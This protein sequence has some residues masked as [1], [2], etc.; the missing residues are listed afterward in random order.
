MAARGLLLC[1]IL[2]ISL[3]GNAAESEQHQFKRAI[4]LFTKAE[5]PAS[6]VILAKLVRQHPRKALYWFN[7]GNACFMLEKYHCAEVTFS[8]VEELKSPLAPAAQLY[9]A[10]ALRAGG[11]SPDARSLLQ[12]LLQNRRLPSG[13]HDMATDELL[14]IDNTNADPAAVEALDLYRARKYNQALKAIDRRQG[15]PDDVLMLKAL[16]LIKLDR[17]DEANK[18]LQKVD[19]ANGDVQLKDLA[20]SLVERMRDKYIRPA[21]VFAEVAGG[22]DSNIRKDAAAESGAALFANIGAGKR[23]ASDNLWQ[24]NAAYIG[25]L[26]EAPGHPDL[27]VY[28]HE[29]QTSYGRAVG[30]DL[31]MLTAFL[32]HESWD[33]KPVQLSEGARLR[34]RTGNPHYEFGGDLELS[35]QSSLNGDHPYV[36]GT[37]ASAHLYAGNISVPFYSQVFLDI[38][39]QAIGDQTYSTG[40]VL[41][42]AYT[43]LGPGGRVLWKF[44]RDWAAEVSA[45][46]MMRDY[47]N[48]VQPGGKKRKDQEL[49]FGARLTRIF[50]PA[51]SGYLSLSQSANSST[52]GPSDTFDLNYQRTL[53]LVGAVWDAL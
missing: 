42:W 6:R 33:S 17:D 47:R 44:S 52:L 29:A 8:K 9:R 5:Y 40:E 32:Q 38:Q 18:V 43:G 53:V 7:L 41:P 49:D 15:N 22:L 16:I 12:T 27:R 24:W 25:R 46:F 4:Q 35:R 34:L 39:R 19:T 14:S 3:T 30:T 50:N 13:L 37:I 48:P 31:M 2:F 26:H 23:L 28:S 51:W 10:K 20:A 1:F 45:G 36:A 21:W 11:N